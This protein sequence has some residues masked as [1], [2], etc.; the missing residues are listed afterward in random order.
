MIETIDRQR[1]RI[2][3]GRPNARGTLRFRGHYEPL[4]GTVTTAVETA[5]QRYRFT[6]DSG[7]VI[8]VNLGA[9]N[10]GAARKKRVVSYDGERLVIE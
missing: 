3:I 1:A 6:L 10:C 9:C 4:E 2:E 8:D 5:P 7:E